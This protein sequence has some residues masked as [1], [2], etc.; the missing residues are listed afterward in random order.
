VLGYPGLAVVEELSSDD[1]KNPWFLLVRF[2]CLPFS[3]WLCLVLV[4]LAVSG[5]SLSLLWVC[6]PVSSLLGDQLSWKNLCSEVCRAAQALGADGYWKDPIPAAP[7]FLSSVCS[8]PPHFRQL[9]E[10]K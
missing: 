2:L 5:W 1:A 8:S 7:L 3:I 4:G 9:L 10:R 6:K